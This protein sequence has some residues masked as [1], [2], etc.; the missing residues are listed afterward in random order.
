M[1]SLD[2]FQ[3]NVI[4]MNGQ[5]MPALRAGR[6]EIDMRLSFE[7]DGPR[8]VV[9][10]CDMQEGNRHFALVIEGASDLDKVIENLQSM[11]TVLKMRGKP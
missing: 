8:A 10:F 9:S 2:L 7:E 1:S 3:L 11:Q 4:T 5:T 6:G